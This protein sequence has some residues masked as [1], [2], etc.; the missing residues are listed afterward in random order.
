MSFGAATNHTDNV[1]YGRVYVAQ[2]RAHMSN[3][4]P[5]SEMVNEA[6]K[7]VSSVKDPELRRVAFEKILHDLINSGD[8]D[9]ESPSTKRRQTN[10]H[11]KAAKGAPASKKPRARAGGPQTYV[12]ELVADKFFAK[13]KTISEVRTELENR[14]H[15]IPLTSLSG[16]LQKLC[17]SKSLRRQKDVTKGK[18]KTFLYSNW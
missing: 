4:K 9:E 13:P 3:S 11:Q 17:Q 16:P 7:A 5:Y 6:E 2:Y 14:G 15:H 18:K 12:E 1:L 10:R 8:S